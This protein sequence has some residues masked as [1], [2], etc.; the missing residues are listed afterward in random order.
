MKDLAIANFNV[1]KALQKLFRY[2]ESS[3]FLKKAARIVQSCGLE[4]S[5]FGKII[6]QTRKEVLE[7][8]ISDPARERR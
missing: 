4:D 6:L 7:V 3:E 2:S 8:R 5:N 1:G